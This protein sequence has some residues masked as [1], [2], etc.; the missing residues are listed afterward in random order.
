MKSAE[1]RINFADAYAKLLKQVP[2]MGHYKQTDIDKGY[3]VR[4]KSR[5]V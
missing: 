1:K 3:A 5:Q 4:C 2:G